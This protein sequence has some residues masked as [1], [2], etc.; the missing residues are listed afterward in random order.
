ML[1]STMNSINDFLK[2]ICRTKANDELLCG[3]LYVD[4]ADIGA[5]F[6]GYERA[7]TILGIDI[8]R[9]SALANGIMQYYDNA[10]NLIWTNYVE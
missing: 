1:R 9:K 7:G 4:F 10:G 6:G 5:Q 2:G 8:R 3:I